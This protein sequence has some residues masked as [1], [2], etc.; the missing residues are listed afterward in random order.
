MVVMFNDGSLNIMLRYSQ[1]DTEDFTLNEIT[2]S[3]LSTYICASQRMALGPRKG[4]DINDVSLDKN[5]FR[6]KFLEKNI[7]KI[8]NPMKNL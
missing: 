5:L 4:V 6:Q 7:I 1:I 3:E 8:A 2:S